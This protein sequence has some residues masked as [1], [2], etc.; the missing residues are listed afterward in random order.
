MA[1]RIKHSVL[2]AFS[3][4]LAAGCSVE[5]ESPFV[6]NRGA[7]DDGGYKPC[8]YT[9]GYWKTHNKY[10]KGKKAVAWPLWEDFVACGDTWLNWLWTPPKGQHKLILAHQ[11]I[12]ALLNQ[13]QGAPIDEEVQN[14]IW[15]G[16]NLLNCEPIPAED[17]EFAMETS[18]TLD[19]FNNG[20]LSA[21]HC[22]D[23]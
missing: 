17:L 4:S 13:A 18:E 7:E 5:A 20:L 22:D 15:A 6:N 14:A 12:A 19:A 9:Q 2:L 11:F 10:A 3:L 23:L 21:P 8:T 16:Q 1:T